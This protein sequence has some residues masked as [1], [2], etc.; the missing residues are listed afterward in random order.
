MALKLIGIDPRP[1]GPRRSSPAAPTTGRP[2]VELEAMPTGDD[3]LIRLWRPQASMKALKGESEFAIAKFLHSKGV[4]GA[5]ARVAA[6]EI[7]SHPAPAHHG[8]ER[9]RRAV[10][11]FFL[12]LGLLLPIT[13]LGL[14]FANVW[15]LFAAVMAAALG[16][17]LLW[18]ASE[19]T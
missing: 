17:K 16:S 6:K 10:G 11:W 2:A 3:E 5:A 13:F 4:E 14:G 9:L 7:V 8:A 15:A 19:K 18:D 12:G 1:D